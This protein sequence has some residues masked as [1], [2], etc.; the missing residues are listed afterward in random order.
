PD[1]RMGSNPALAT[2]EHGQRFYELAVKELSNTYLEW[3]SCPV[4]ELISN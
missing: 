2:P 1:G 3:L 4:S